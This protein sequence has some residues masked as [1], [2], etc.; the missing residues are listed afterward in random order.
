MRGLKY[1]IPVFIS[2]L[3][4]GLYELS[5]GWTFLIAITLINQANNYLGEFNAVELREELHYFNLNKG[6]QWL[7]M[8]SAIFFVAWN[9]WSYNFLMHNDLQVLDLV[10]F[11]ISAAIINC[12]FSLSLAHDLL[13]KGQWFKSLWAQALLIFCGVPHFKNDHLFG[14]HQNASTDKDPSSAYKGQSYYSFI[15][16]LIP[17]RIQQ[18]YTLNKAYPTAKQMWIL[19]ENYMLR[20][21]MV[22]LYAGLI[23]LS[24]LAS[25]MAIYLVVHAA[26]VYL[27][28]EMSNYIQHYGL[29]REG[30]TFSTAHAWDYLHKYS[31]YISYLLPLHSYHHANA[32]TKK[33]IEIDE[34]TVLPYCYYRMMMLALIP[35][36]WF[37]KMDGLTAVKGKE[38]KPKM[39]SSTVKAACVAA[40]LGI[41]ITSSAQHNFGIK[42]FGLSMHPRGDEQS[43]LMP[44]RLD[45]RGVLVVNFGGIASY[46]KYVYTNL[47]SFKL[48]QGIYTDSG[49]L[50]SGHTHLGFRFRFIERGRHSAMFGFG[51]TMV[52]RRSWKVKEGYESTGLFKE[53]GNV[54]YLFVWYGGEIEYN[55]LLSDKLDLSINFL[56]GYPLVMSFGVGLRY[57]PGGFR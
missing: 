12:T 17:F 24:P 39:L 34:N 47:L 27:M 55:Y 46:Q 2:L 21:L 49:G 13:H 53:K 28:F 35:K 44:Y 1:L 15:L 25:Q 41:S 51:P 42:Y 22:L 3:F 5:W 4:V 18:S 16:K 56:P 7:K 38:I 11:T 26:F 20:G 40:L 9:F 52:Y 30:A 43:H 10:N 14:H 37:K 32:S 29:R 6:F 31:N 45:D 8:L 33:G 23:V 19:L 54:Q 50:I 36:L 48:A 57:W